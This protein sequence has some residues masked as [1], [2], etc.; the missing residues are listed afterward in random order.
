MLRKVAVLPLLAIVC[1]SNALADPLSDLL[2]KQ[3]GAVCFE[4]TYDKA[5]LAGNP[6]QKTRTA[7]LSLQALP[8][9]AVVIRIHFNR[10]DGKHYIVGSCAWSEN[11]N[12]DVQGEKLIETF[13]GP[14]GLDCHA[15][16]SADGMSAEE[17]GDFPVDL[18]D[19][20]SISLYVPESLAAWKSFD[21]S[22]A[23]GWVEFGKDDL[24]F[25]LDP[26]DAAD[27]GEIDRETALVG[28]NTFV[29]RST[30]CQIRVV[31]TLQTHRRVLLQRKTG[32]S[33]D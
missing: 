7:L 13:K 23:A 15:M 5:H 18:R 12:L 27:C 31:L 19:G 16:T 30:Y 14:S 21:R 32:E 8:D 10:S 4:R 25:R 28:V 3:D 2:A 20:G 6:G 11:A 33:D 26:T 1:T 22:A 24:I 29:H 17:G 9:G